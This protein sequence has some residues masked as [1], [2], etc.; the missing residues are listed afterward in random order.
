MTS[1]SYLIRLKP[2]QPASYKFR[3]TRNRPFIQVV[4]ISHHSDPSIHIM[5]RLIITSCHL[6]HFHFE[7]VVNV[8]IFTALLNHWYIGVLFLK[9]RS[10]MSLLHSFCLFGVLLVLFPDLCYF[11]VNLRVHVML[12]VLD[13]V[14]R[15]VIWTNSI[16][17]FVPLVVAWVNFPFLTVLVSQLHLHVH[18]R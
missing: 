10:V 16:P 15:F 9:S 8:S 6:T 11:P 1:T 7:Q 2:S 17:H 5:T 18:W 13:R 14:Q 3:R 4:V 12:L